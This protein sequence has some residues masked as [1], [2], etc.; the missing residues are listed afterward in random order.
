MRFV[1][2]VYNLIVIGLVIIVFIIFIPKDLGSARWPRRGR[3]LS[4]DALRS[5]TADTASPG[6]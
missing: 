2:I 3:R 6:S 5:R 1:G 4:A